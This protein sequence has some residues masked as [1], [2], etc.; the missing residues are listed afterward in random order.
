MILE[1]DV[2]KEILAAPVAKRAITNLSALNEAYDYS[3]P[4]SF[5]R[6]RKSVV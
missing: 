3:K 5:S 4:S 2:L 6:D 1:A